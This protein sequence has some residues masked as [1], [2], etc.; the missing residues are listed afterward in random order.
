MIKNNI[1]YKFL[2]LKKLK[3]YTIHINPINQI[4]AKT[5]S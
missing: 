4:Q 1:L 2:A 5:K 3:S